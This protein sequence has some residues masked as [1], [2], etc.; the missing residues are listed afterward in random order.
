MRESEQ[1]AGELANRTIAPAPKSER[2]ARIA[3][4]CCSS[5]SHLETMDG[6]LQA[7]LFFIVA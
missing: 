5:R 2:I 1:G 3:E 4:C 6:F 7:A